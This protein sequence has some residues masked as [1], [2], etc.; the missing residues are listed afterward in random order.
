MIRSCLLSRQEIL[1]MA[2]RQPRTK[3]GYIYFPRFGQLVQAEGKIRDTGFFY[4]RSYFKN[5]VVLDSE[6][7]LMW[8]S[9][10]KLKIDETLKR[11]IDSRLADAL[12]GLDTLKLKDVV[13]GKDYT[14][15]E[16]I[17]TTIY[18]TKYKYA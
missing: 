1:E 15:E 2:N 17:D 13:S 8:M 6:D 3:D 12:D 10:R 9:K 5:K 14:L 7:I 4:D 11:L 18:I 16:L